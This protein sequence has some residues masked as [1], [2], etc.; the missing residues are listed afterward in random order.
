MRPRL[1]WLLG[2]YMGWG[3]Q[4]RGAVLNP[5][6]ARKNMLDGSCASATASAGAVVDPGAH[7]GAASAAAIGVGGRGREA[8]NGAKC[9]GREAASQHCN[10]EF[11]CATAQHNYSTALLR[12][13]LPMRVARKSKPERRGDASTTETLGDSQDPTI[14]E[15]GW[16][17]HLA[18]KAPRC[19][20]RRRPQRAGAPEQISA[21]HGD[22]AAMAGVDESRVG[23]ARKC[24]HAPTYAS[25]WKNGLR[26]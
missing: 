7:I 22:A 1:P 5:I 26:N 4:D 21:T 16:R 2:P 10:N 13:H 14:S 9:G 11:Q 12:I 19:Q 15:A 6:C 20:R 24:W 8:E 17:K 25:R 23:R 3:R 18:S